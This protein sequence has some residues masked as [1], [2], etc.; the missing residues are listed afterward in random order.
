VSVRAELSN[1]TGYS[2]GPLL[3]L[4]PALGRERL[5]FGS[6]RGSLPAVIRLLDERTFVITQLTSAQRDQ[7]LEYVLNA[8]V[9]LQ[10]E[11]GKGGPAAGEA[12]GEGPGITELDL[13]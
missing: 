3:R 2:L 5:L 4:T 6:Q 1:F 11:E 9:G 7:F 10:G 13:S 12:V 8:G